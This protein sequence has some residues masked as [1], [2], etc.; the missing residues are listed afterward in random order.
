VAGGAAALIRPSMMLFLPPACAIVAAARWRRAGPLRALGLAALFAA[1]WMATISPATLRNH[2]MSGKPVLITAGQAFTFV[3]FN[4][5]EGDHPQYMEAFDGTILSAGRVLFQI[6]V[7]HPAEMLRRFAGKAG[8]SLGMVHWHEGYAAHPELVLTSVLYLAAF[9]LV[10]AA[11]RLAAV[12]VHAFI[13]A[14]LATLLLTTPWNYGYRLLLVMYLLMPVFAVA[15]LARLWA[16][17]R[18]AGDSPLRAP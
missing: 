16:W 2:I 13:A 1:A 14:H 7:D 10:P 8:F 5:P 4:L 17:R 12:P 6:I 18:P 15:T 11:R 9:L 3:E